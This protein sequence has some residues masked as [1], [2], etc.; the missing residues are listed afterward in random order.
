MPLFLFKKLKVDMDDFILKKIVDKSVDF[1]KNSE[2]VEAKEKL[3]EAAK[4][5]EEIE[6]DIRYKNLKNV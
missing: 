6:Q 4:E 3:I 5:L 2:W 1:S